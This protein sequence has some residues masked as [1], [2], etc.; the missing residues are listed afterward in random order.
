MSEARPCLVIVDG[1]AVA[2]RNYH[3]GQ[4]ILMTSSGE[5]TNATF[6]FARALLDI[7][8]SDPPP[9]YLAVA[10][11]QGLSGR[12]LAFP[13]Y[14]SQRPDLEA[15]L[16]F[17]LGRI[18]QLVEAFN[19]PILE[20]EGCEAD[21]VIGSIARQ[22]NAQGIH[23]HIV[24]GDQDLF[25]LV[26]ELTTLELP[27]RGGGNTR[28]DAAAVYAKLGVRPEQ[29]PD[30]KGLVGDSSDNI[31][32]VKG[33]GE[34]TAV[35]LLQTYGTLE[36]IYANLD[37]I[38]EKIRAKLI[39]GR[40]SAFLSRQ[41]ATI[42][43]DLPVV[44]DL[45]RC[46]AQ[47]YDYKRVLA[48]FRELEFNS[49]IR[50]LQPPAPPK[51][52]GEQLTLLNAPQTP[53]KD[54]PEPE[55]DPDLVPA[56]STFTLHL[57]DTPE[58]LEALVGRLKTATWLAFDTET[59]SPDAN[60]AALVGISLAMSAEDGY[61][62]PVGHAP[63]A[64]ERQLPLETVLTALKPVLTDPNI[65]K[66]AH[67]AAFDLNVLS[68]YGVS[69]QPLSYDTQLAEALLQPERRQSLKDSARARF[70]VRMTRIEELI[71]KGKAQITMDRVPVAQVAPYAAADA[72]FTFRLIE[73]TRRDLQAANLWT[74]Y[75]RIELPLA[76]IIAEMNANGALVD[77]A[78]LESLSAEFTARLAEIEQRIQD[79]AGEPFNVGS[80][81]QLNDILFGKLKLP[82]KGLRKSQHGYSLDADALEALH[83]QHPIIPL[84]IE[85]RALEKLHS[86]YV[87]ALA[88]QADADGRVHTTYRQLGT[89]TGRLSSENPNLQNIPIR[90]E[91]GRRVRRAF[92]APA[93]WQL[94]S[95]DYS[96][97]ELR[98]LAHY[99][100]DEAL[101]QAF[102]QELDIHRATAALV[103]NVPYDQVTKEQRY[104]AKRVNF[105]LLYGMGAQRL[106]RESELNRAEA[107]QFIQN[108]FARLPGVRRYLD[109]TKVRAREQGYLETLL[110][111]RRD[112]SALRN[113]NLS[114]V[115]RARIE[116]EAINMPIQG[117]A[118][119]IVKVAMVNLH[120]A[121]RESGFRARL[122]LQVHDELVLEAPEDELARLVPLVRTT[123]ESAYQLSV[124]L[125][126]EV[127]IGANWAEM[128]SADAWLAR[129]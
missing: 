49:L 53:S 86:T 126:A 2:H 46:V 117:T 51:R 36:G 20:R 1:H 37:A 56:E 84:L 43:T 31:P 119:D 89:V 121:L 64:A 90:T 58:T 59:S 61:Y 3:S 128:E 74:L 78:Y 28:Y 106:A 13:A 124:P 112:F 75:E 57:V 80:L 96:Q 33:I 94:L 39:E 62:I 92:I 71:G 77:L 85:W 65:A 69:V 87:V 67:N 122:I 16:A 104:F 83:D 42:R 105:G 63:E 118:A 40:E 98:I 99:S 52:E 38:P 125:R 76:P 72:V 116:R 60:T 123:M 21:D 70:S 41:L 97:I 73:P 102:H 19:I 17:Q 111:R 88:R 27:D 107:E 129:R 45:S 25:Q 22:A 14:K 110:G 82:T 26:N 93:G 108:Y 95:T 24:T 103:S 6:G 8:R 18:R 11:D 101:R 120:R 66:A 48:L 12:D 68:R 30:Y 35:P 29:V 113:Q 32:G 15:S 115:E 127:N 81:K 114:Q 91:E 5:P 100:G 34:K 7:L 9:H 23:V 55:D 109:E 4:R 50:R 44:L 54:S 47:D 79:L 10:F